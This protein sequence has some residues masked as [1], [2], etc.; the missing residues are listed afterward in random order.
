MARK[1]KPR[2]WQSDDIIDDELQA[3]ADALAAEREQSVIPSKAGVRKALRDLLDARRRRSMANEAAAAL[4]YGVFD[5]N[6]ERDD[7]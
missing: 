7:Y 3:E 5:P 6:G 1:R 4:G 2:A